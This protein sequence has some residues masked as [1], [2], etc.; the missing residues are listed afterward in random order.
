[1]VTGKHLMPSGTGSGVWYHAAWTDEIDP[2]M[3]VTN[4]IIRESIDGMILC[5]EAQMYM[6]IEAFK[7]LKS[8]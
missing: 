5:V 7:K 1:M 8:E 2:W 3:N 6:F 4:L